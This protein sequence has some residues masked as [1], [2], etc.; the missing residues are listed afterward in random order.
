MENIILK[1]VS[2]LKGYAEGLEISERSDE[3]KLLR[4]IVEVIDE[5]ADKVLEL[6]AEQGAIVEQIELIDD[7][8]AELEEFVYGDEEGSLDEEDDDDFDYFEIECPNCKQT[9]YIDDDFLDDDSPI[10]CPNCDQEIELDFSCCDHDEDHDH[11]NN[12]AGE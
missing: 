7:D 1:K 11:N 5:I 12:E 3:G 9:V 4:K 8:L 10:V 6:D 2:Y